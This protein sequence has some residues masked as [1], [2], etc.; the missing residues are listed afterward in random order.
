MLLTDPAEPVAQPLDTDIAVRVRDV[1]KVYGIWSSPKAR[2]AHP[3]LTMGAQLLPSSRLARSVD[4]R[5]RN[6]YRDFHALRDVS[7]DIRKGESWGFIG[8]NGS[9]KSTLLKIISGNLRPSAGSVEVDGKVA[10][11]DYGAGFNGEFT[12]RENVYLKASILGLKRRQIDERFASIASFADIGEFIEQPVKT[13][14]SGM[15]A[16]LGF[17]IMAHVDADIMITDEALAVGDSFFVQKCM[18]HIHS[19]LKKGTFLFVS[20]STSD[21]MTL[22]DMAVWLENGKVRQIGVSKDVCQAYLSSRDRRI[23]AEYLKSDSDDT[24]KTVANDTDDSQAEMSARLGPRAPG[25]LHLSSRQVAALRDH[26]EPSQNQSAVKEARHASFTISQE[27]VRIDEI[28]QGSSGVGGGRVVMVALTRN[29]GATLASVLGGEEV[30]LK[31]TAV[32]D[33]DLAKPILGFQLMNDRGLTLFAENS[34]VA[35][36]DAPFPLRSGDAVTA[37]F[38]FRMPLLPVGDYMF[39]VGFADG[40]EHNNA[41]LDVRMDALLLRCE[42]SGARHGLVGVPL[43]GLS[44]IRE[45]GAIFKP[46]QSASGVDET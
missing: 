38:A 39:R 20:H 40:D 43:L 6:M 13:Y 11:L 18:R 21:V 23:S 14:S 33:R 45:E 29:D 32:A 9:G 26:F 24:G 27:C 28:L 19:F 41:L 1:S 31:V 46:L 12:G 4:H 15:S 25:A 16:R 3:L 34:S 7:F 30:R 36:Q 2:L 17:A 42:T 5:T 37:Q 35:T 22:C 44:L 10:I 8:V